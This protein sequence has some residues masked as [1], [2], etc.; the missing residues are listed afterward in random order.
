MI[1]LSPLYANTSQTLANE[2]VEKIR[3]QQ[4]PSRPNGP[5]KKPLRSA[6][7]GSGRGDLGRGTSRLP[8]VVVTSVAMVM[9]ITSLSNSIAFDNNLFNKPLTFDAWV[10]L[11]SAAAAKKHKFDPTMYIPFLLHKILTYFVG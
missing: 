6:P 7:P 2:L 10:P 1:F 3:A 5:R 9:A 4:P 11:P 8:L